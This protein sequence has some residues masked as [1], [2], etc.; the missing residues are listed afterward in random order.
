MLPLPSFK[1][2]HVQI[3]LDTA[4]G[5]SSTPH[6]LLKKKEDIIVVMARNNRHILK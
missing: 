3:L 2:C 4:V 6:L 1:F 5:D